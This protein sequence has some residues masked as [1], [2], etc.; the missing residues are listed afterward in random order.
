[1]VITILLLL[2]AGILAGLIAGLLGLGGGI[3]FAPVL[4]FLFQ[5]SGIPD[6]VVWT[7]AT[8]L[9]CNFVTSLS[10][11]V[12]H[13]QMGN[14]YP[15]EGLMVGAFGVAGTYAG[16]I[17][18][19]STYYSERE[20][21]IFFSIILFYSVY[22]FLKK[23]KDSPL[24]AGREVLPMRWYHGVSIGFSAGMLAALA[25]VGGGLILVPAMSIFLAFG[26]KKV[27]SIS[28]MAIVIITL[29]GWIQLG[30]I[31]P[32]SAGFSGLHWGYVDFGAALP[33]LAGGVVGARYGVWLLDVFRLRTIEIFFGILVLFVALR[34]LYGLF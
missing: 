1:M 33:L 16:R 3:L 28:S 18:A 14:V 11:S 34:L 22:H 5:K 25:G 2:L 19:T 20:F 21:I 10:S 31:A 32:G 30:M 15:K 12:K 23:K 8:S 9:F 7:I 13:M 27:V 17:I 6:P 29:A 24:D 4:L 26:F